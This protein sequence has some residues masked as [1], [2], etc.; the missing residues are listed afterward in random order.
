MRNKLQNDTINIGLRNQLISGSMALVIVSLFVSRGALSVSMAGFIAIALFHRDIK[1]QVRCF[2][3]T[4]YLWSISLLFL[5]PFISG[6]W[7]QDKE[8]WIHVVKVKL[9]FLFLPLAFAGKWQLN[10]A[11]GRF[12]TGFF[13]LAVLAGTGWSISQYLLNMPVIQAAYLKAKTMPV[14]L[15]GDHIRFSWLVAIAVII[16]LL[17]SVTETN[18]RIKIL[19]LLAALWL[20]IYLHILAARTGLFALYLF[21]P[22][23]IIFY[24][25]GKKKMPF[26]IATISISLLLAIVAWFYFPT[27]QNR[28]KYLRYNFDFASN[29][30]YLPGG[31]DATRV[32]SLKAGWQILKDNPMGAGAGDVAA[33]ANAWYNKYV[34]GMEEA[35]KIYPS[36][37]WLIHGG[38]AGWAGLL[39]FTVIAFFPFFIRSSNEKFGW[40]CFHGAA[41]LT[42]LTDSSIEVQYGV[43]IY[44][45][46]TCYWW[47]ILNTQNR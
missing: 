16:A 2:L 3:A 1:E 18:S 45:F 15:G 29:S 37:E 9:P 33:A 47:K 23:F 39:A 27:F 36:N 28:F 30:S 4:P 8:T 21:I 44:C 32:L 13:L 20:A 46:I 40:Y 7:S 6:L 42:F 25:S 43:F 41:L 12:I 24:L 38:F 5:I 26:A 10:T 31:T 19:L 17:S 35:D 11:Q 22:A 34:P 14:P